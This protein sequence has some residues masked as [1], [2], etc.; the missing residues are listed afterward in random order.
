MLPFSHFRCCSSRPLGLALKPNIFRFFRLLRVTYTPDT[1][2]DN[3][4]T[5][6]IEREDH[7]I[8]N[9]LRM[10]LLRDPSVVFVGYKHPHP[11]E[12]YIELRVRTASS[13]RAGA[14]NHPP[15]A[16]RNALIDLS[17]EALRLSEQLKPFL[18]QPTNH[19]R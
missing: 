17:S 5:F 4:G 18:D 3:C 2:V 8:G 13:S 14:R 15:E 19:R 16:V 11:I 6:R 12:H 7:T 9:L 1:K 10:Q